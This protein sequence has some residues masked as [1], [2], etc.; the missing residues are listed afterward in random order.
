MVSLPKLMVPPDEVKEVVPLR[1]LV[2]VVGRVAV[3]DAQA[4]VR[5]DDA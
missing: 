4:G 5:G 2:V 1:E 3:D